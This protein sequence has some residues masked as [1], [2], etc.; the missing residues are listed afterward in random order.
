MA[1]GLQGLS[2][3]FLHAGARAA[4]GTAWSVEDHATAGL[5]EAVY[6]RLVAGDD[7]A[8]ALAGAQRALLGSRPWARAGEWAAF[9]LHGDPAARPRLFPAAPRPGTDL[10]VVL[11]SLAAAAALL[12][13]GRSTRKR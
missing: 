10:R 3:A 12:L 13:L 11:A 2:L 7:D 8:D 5:I 4:V 6:E 9:V 1:E